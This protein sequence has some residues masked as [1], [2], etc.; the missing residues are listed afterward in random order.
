MVCRT[1]IRIEILNKGENVMKPYTYQDAF[2]KYPEHNENLLHFETI[3]NGTGIRSGL[4][5]A[6]H[7][8]APWHVQAVIHGFEINFWPHTMKA[9]AQGFGTKATQHTI[10]NMINSIKNEKDFEVVEL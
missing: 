10:I 4:Y 6:N 1:E 3:I 8:K 2:N 5:F 9:H 7:E